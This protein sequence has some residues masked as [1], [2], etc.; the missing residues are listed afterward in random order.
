MMQTE[1]SNS[2]LNQFLSVKSI[3][4]LFISFACLYYVYINFD[5]SS[6]VKEILNLNYF[7]LLLSFFVLFLSLIVRAVRWK[8]IFGSED[9]STYDL[10]RSEVLGFW[11][12]SVF[13]LKIGE[14]IKIHYA[15]LLTFKKYSFVLGT[16][17]IER[18]IDFF[19]ISPFIFLLYMFFP[20]DIIL[21]KINFFIISPFIFLLYIFFPND[22]ILDKINFFIIMILLIIGFSVLYKYFLHSFSKKIMNNIDEKLFKNFLK[23][24]SSILFSTC[25]LCILI[26][27]DVYFIQAAMANLKLSIF[28]CFCIMLVGTIIYII[29]SS[30]GTFGTFHLAIQE[31]LVVFLNKPEAISKAF[32]F[33]LH[34]HSY[35]FFIGLGNGFNTS[36]SNFF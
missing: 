6:F 19:L 15:K 7:Y 5:S 2:I 14:L 27:L 22:I 35:I 20:N 16:I 18:L 23:N 31:F 10:Y 21:D 12:N 8:Q 11:G 28:E 29:P 4:G 9:I 33:I 13:P 3:L 25:I 36:T 1:K 24:K 32:A 34:A 26:F 17:I 30:P